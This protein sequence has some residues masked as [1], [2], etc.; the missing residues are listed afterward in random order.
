LI[1]NE[2]QRGNSINK[3]NL[4][5]SFQSRVKYI[6]TK[7]TMRALKEHNISSLLIA[8][9]VSANKGLRDELT[10]LCQENNIN[11]TVPP[12]KYCTDNATM[13]AAAAYVAY[14]K[15]IVSD[16]SLNAIA[17]IPIDKIGVE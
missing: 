11:F 1:H 13:I 16:L 12:L 9:G 8:G 5:K 4:A 2:E 10:K 3:E 17:T 6:L 15:G 14:Q 7:K